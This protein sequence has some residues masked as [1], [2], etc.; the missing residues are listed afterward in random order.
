[1]SGNTHCQV[2][3]VDD[4][5]NDIF[6]L[7]RAMEKAGIDCP[8]QVVSDGEQAIRYLAGEEKYAN[9]SAHPLP[10]VVF[11]DLKMPLLDG[12]GVLEWRLKHPELASLRI[13]VLTGSFM[14]AD[15]TRAL[16]LGA[17]DFLIKPATPEILRQVFA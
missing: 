8:V 17:T 11:L 13:F 9:R 3:I 5:D 4:D 7:G 15:R 14:E 16:Q 2:L 10:D 6:F 12:F 1:M